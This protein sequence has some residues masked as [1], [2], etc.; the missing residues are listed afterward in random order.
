MSKESKE[1]REIINDIHQAI[2]NLNESYVFNKTNNDII[3]EEDGFQNEVTSDISSNRI[4]SPKVKNIDS[5]IKEIRRIALSVIG[6]LT[7]MDNQD[8]YKLVKG[9]WDS[10]DKF[11]TKDNQ[12]VQPK[13]NNNK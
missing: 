2:G 4:S 11:L 6:E 10:C 8:A 5:E 13:I 9:I 3:P 7:P 1:I 12:Q